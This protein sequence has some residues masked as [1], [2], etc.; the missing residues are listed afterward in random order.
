MLPVII[1]K[2]YSNS[3]YFTITRNNFLIFIAVIFFVVTKVRGRWEVE[4]LF[5][6]LNCLAKCN[7]IIM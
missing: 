3:L 7:L 4:L 5:S 6:D 2:I 1:D